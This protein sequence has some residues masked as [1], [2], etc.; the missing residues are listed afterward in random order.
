MVPLGLVL[1]SAVAAGAE[2]PQFRGPDGQGHAT[3]QDLPLAWS[4][5]DN[6]VWKTAIPGLG[7][8]SPVIQD[9]QIWLTTG[10]DEGR[11]LRAV[12]INR[13][14]GSLLHDVE[15]FRLEEPGHV[16]KKNSHASPTPI[17]DGR[18]VYV[19]FGA[20]GTACLST[21]GRIV[22][23]TQE[24]SYDHRHG[25]GGSPE[26]YED[27]LIFSCDG[28]D[29]QFV[30]ALDK[31]TGAVRWKT[32]RPSRHAYSTPLLIRVDGH[33]QLVST[34]ADATMGYDPRTGRELW[35]FTYDGYSLVPRPVVGHGLVFIC[36]GYNTPNVF[37]LRL[38]R[39][40]TLTEDD[41][42]W[43]LKRGAPHNPSPLLVGAEIYL[44]S[45]NGIA[46]C[47][48]A[49]TGSPHWQER[50]GGNFSA[51]PL[52][53]AGRIYFLDEEGVATVVAEG[54]QFELL[55]RNAIEGRTLASPAVADGS[56]FLRS[57][58]HLYRIQQ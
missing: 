44:V 2:W 38:G 37:A 17:I 25:P 51:S 1:W 9:R 19:H 26:L 40:G 32:E 10:V 27:L 42:A 8:S 34:G 22:W 53:A 39:Q 23:R 20:H 43:S 56:L 36:T 14:D 49:V 5:T 12:C 57:D 11:S 55:A 45:D 33:D 46:T 24:N 50:L 15:V 21:D 41:V 54:R 58:T 30:V 18:R 48:D 31:H 47:L 13:D 29:Q 35:R 4:E 28:Y 7:W 6:V 3:D 52:A 16:H